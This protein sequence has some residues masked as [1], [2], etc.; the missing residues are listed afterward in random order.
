[1]KYRVESNVTRQPA[2]QWFDYAPERLCAALNMDAYHAGR[3]GEFGIYK[4]SGEREE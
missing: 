2:S 4:D 3:G 1:M